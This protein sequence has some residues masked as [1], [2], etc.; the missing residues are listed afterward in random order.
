MNNKILTFALIVG[1]VFG[2]TGCIGPEKNRPPDI[3]SISLPAEAEVNEEVVVTTRSVDPDRD[4]LCYRIRFG[5]GDEDWSDY[6]PSGQ[7]VA[8]THKYKEASNYGVTARAYDRKVVSEWSEE[9]WIRIKTS[10][11]PPVPRLDPILG[12]C[13]PGCEQMMWDL[14]FR[15][16]YGNREGWPN[17]D[18]L[19]RLGLKVFVNI[20]TDGEMTEEFVK[21]KVLE[22]KDRPVC[23][24]W[25]SDQLGHEPDIL[26]PSLE[27]RTE[28]YN[29]VRKYDPGL[30]AIQKRPVMEMFNC[31]SASD[32]SSDVMKRW[33]LR[34]DF[35]PARLGEQVENIIKAGKYP[36]WEGA[37]PKEGDTIPFDALMI[38]L[39]AFADNDEDMAREIE[40]LF[41][42][43]II[44]YN[45]TKQLIP[46]INA[47]MYRPGSI[48]CAYNTWKRLLALP[49]Y[50]NPY[51]GLPFTLAYY[52]DLA[53]RENWELQREI[54][55][56]NE[57]M[58]KWR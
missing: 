46:Q 14:L 6:H 37:F 5:D 58:A 38:D 43:F 47:Y 32:S 24:G 30:E 22:Y 56:V 18:E 28:F 10:Q 19:E 57:E 16:S 44:P 52:C 3:P 12:T 2:L 15:S 21:A 7:E 26:G 11:P 48:W 36:G 31:T 8:F 53:V 45:K 29:W 42:K 20:R 33:K 41:R 34:S 17:Y 4:E 13:L 49:E 27:K 25:W 51:R 55:E 35:Y 39:Y 54:R 50:D 23:G 1:L 40:R 9:K